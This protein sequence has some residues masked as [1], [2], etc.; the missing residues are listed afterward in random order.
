MGF[1]ESSLDNG[2]TDEVVDSLVAWGDED[3]IAGRL[4]EHLEAGATQVCIQALDPEGNFRPDERILEA[5]APK[6]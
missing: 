3:T 1:E 2:G 6:G 4:E 5:L